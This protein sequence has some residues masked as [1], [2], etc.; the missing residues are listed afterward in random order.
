MNKDVKK[1][2]IDKDMTIKDLVQKTG[3]TRGHLSG[4]IHGRLD[5]PKAQ[6]AIAAALGVEFEGLWD[7]LTL[8]EIPERDRAAHEV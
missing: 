5:S 7:T 6:R 8:P 1:L 4:V 3:Y 2:L